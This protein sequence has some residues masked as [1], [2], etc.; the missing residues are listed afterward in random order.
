MNGTNLLKIKDR[1]KFMRG[2]ALSK[3]QN[4]ESNMKFVAFHAEWLKRTSNKEWSKRRRQLVDSL[5]RA[6]RH[7]TLNSA[8]Q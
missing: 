8:K 4:F 5:Y 3:K 6:N 1:K 2:L 7:L